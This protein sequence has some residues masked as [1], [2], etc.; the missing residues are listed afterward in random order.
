[1]HR[2]IIAILSLLFTII[3]LTAPAQARSLPIVSAKTSC[4][5]IT[6]WQTVAEGAKVTIQSA[7]LVSSEKSGSFCKVMGTIAPQTHFEL[8]LPSTN[9]HQRMLF[10]GCGGFCGFVKIRPAAAVGCLA[11]DNGE[12]VTVATDMGHTSGVGDTSWASRNPEARAN[13]GYRANHLTTLATKSIIQ[14]VYGQAARYAYFSGCSDGGREAMIEAQRYPH[15]YNGIIAGA[16][17]MN[18]TANN[19]IYHAWLTQHLYARDGAPLISSEELLAVK[20]AAI[21]KCDAQDSQKDGLI[22]RPW[23]C[24]FDPKTVV[25]GTNLPAPCLTD[26]QA[27]L[28]AAIYTGPV[29]TMR[30][31]LYFGAPIG[32]EAS[33]LA[34]AKMSQNFAASFITNFTSETAAAP[35]NAFDATYTTA[36][37]AKY[38]HFAPI[39]NATNPNLAHFFAAG[40]KLIMWH[41]AADSSVPMGSSLAYYRKLHTLYGNSLGQHAKLYMLPAVGHCG[42]GDGPDQFDMLSKIIAWS[43]DGQAPKAVV[44]HTKTGKEWSI[45]PFHE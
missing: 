3:T 40:G 38:N 9:W 16:A 1:M 22:A 44:A 17:V 43:E 27:A 32:S 19:S 6:G 20:T 13:F 8:H 45:A 31:P 5:T 2:F 30:N 11:L 34:Q 29:G 41:G 15:D 18:H 25:C 26:T 14:H 4:D 33:W 23:A 7:E 39:L 37:I 35:V 28:V 36:D 42:G 24:D 12:M 21:A 10:T